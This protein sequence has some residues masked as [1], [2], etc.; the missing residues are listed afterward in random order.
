[1]RFSARKKKLLLCGE[2]CMVNVRLRVS[3]KKYPGYTKGIQ[4]VGRNLP[5]ENKRK[6]L[7]F[8]CVESLS[9]DTTDIGLADKGIRVNGFDDMED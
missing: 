2:Y 7:V 5:Y 9:K 8:D 6:L 1:M 4:I 3:K